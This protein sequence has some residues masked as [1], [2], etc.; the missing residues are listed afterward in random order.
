[1]N[2]IVLSLTLALSSAAFADEYTPFY[3]IQ[4]TEDG[5]LEAQIGIVTNI[6]GPEGCV[7]FQGSTFN[8]VTHYVFGFKWVM[9]KGEGSEWVDM[10]GTEPLEKLCGIVRFNGT[11]PTISGEYRPVLELH[12]GERIGKYTSSN[13]L[14]VDSN[15]NTRV[16]AGDGN[17][18]VVGGDPEDETAVE[19]AGDE[20]AAE[21]VEDETAVEAV[22][23]GFLKS[24]AT[25]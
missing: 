1:M 12:R 4:V 20:S 13:T 8:G 18:V 17:T 23:W 9:R 6:L 5:G 3:S 11:M 10:P 21:E 24:R 25:P 7:S 19:E 22:T 2:T 15:G 14:V 16:V